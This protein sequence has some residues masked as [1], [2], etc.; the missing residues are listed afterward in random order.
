MTGTTDDGGENGAG[1][2]VTGESSLAHTRPVV[3]NQSSY[4]IRH[5]TVVDLSTW[6]KVSTKR[7]F[8]LIWMNHANRTRL[9]CLECRRVRL[10]SPQ[11]QHTRPTRKSVQIIIPFRT[12]LIYS[13]KS[14][15]VPRSNRAFD[16]F[17]TNN[18]CLHLANVRSN[19]CNVVCSK[20]Y[21]TP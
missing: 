9:C 1:R 18:W 17:P 10:Q 20:N 7:R 16:K 11:D 19:V 8:L 21:R 2:I 4:F 12:Q 13:I 3:D 14:H 6:E 15:N 5:S